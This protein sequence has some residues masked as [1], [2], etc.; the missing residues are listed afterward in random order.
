ML[1]L[2]SC[3]KLVVLLETTKIIRE[4]IISYELPKTKIAA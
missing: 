3:H 4:P 2:L 1:E